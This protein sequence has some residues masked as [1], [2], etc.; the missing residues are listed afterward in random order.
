MLG[1]GGFGTVFAVDE[2][3]LGALGHSGKVAV[4]RM[5]DCNMQGV[6]Q[7][8]NEIDI[9]ALCRHEHLLPLLGFCLEAEARCLVYPLMAGGTLEDALASSAATPLTW[10]ARVRILSATARALLFLHTPSGAK[11]VI[12]HRD[13]KSANI[14]LD[15]HLNAKLSDVGLA[16]L[17]PRQKANLWGTKV[18]GFP[19]WASERS[20]LIA[21]DECA[22]ADGLPTCIPHQVIGHL[23][24]EVTG[25]IGYLD[26]IYMASGMYTTMADAYAMG[27]TM[28]VSFTGVDAVCAM[29]TCNEMLE[30]PSRAY[31][32]AD[33]RAEWPNDE[34]CTRL[35]QIIQVM[36]TSDCLL[37]KPALGS[38]RSSR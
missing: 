23:S 22:S 28:L 27:I 10:K 8:Q 7:L 36:M 9:L 2:G 25:T 33:A 24:D 11:G 32:Y 6:H 35:A 30:A 31:E 3:R 17:N 38:L 21:F 4:K 15:H 14:L 20:A 26:P 34:T 18:I 1:K 37:T 19:N 12:L 29:R 16:L 5:D 13:V